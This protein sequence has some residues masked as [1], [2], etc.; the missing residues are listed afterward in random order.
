MVVVQ[1]NK[2]FEMQEKKTR[3]NQ[4]IIGSEAERRV[5]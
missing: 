5:M 1:N 2:K 3:Y 4:K